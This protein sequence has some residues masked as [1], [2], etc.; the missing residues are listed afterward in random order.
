[1]V[2]KRGRFRAGIETLPSGATID[3]DFV[4]DT[5]VKP[6]ERRIR[7]SCAK[8]GVWRL[9]KCVVLAQ[10]RKGEKNIC[11]DCHMKLR[12][13]RQR[14]R[15]LEMARKNIYGYVVRA[16]TFF[17]TDQFEFLK[18]MMRRSTRE[19]K[20]NVVKWDILEHRAVMALHLGRCLNSDE[21]VHHKNG[22]KDDNRIENLELA[23]PD[24]HGLLHRDTVKEMKALRS[25]VEELEDELRRIKSGK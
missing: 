6:R 19:S 25:R 4:E 18:P 15:M 22:I 1:M 14:I 10:Y 24:S 9:V 16:A 11:W 5:E 7:V 3:W 12:R 13:E 2:M 23:S 8:C 17:T 21:V 20:P